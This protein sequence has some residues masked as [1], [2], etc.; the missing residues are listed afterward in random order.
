MWEWWG[1][2]SQMSNRYPRRDVNQEAKA[3]VITEVKTQEY[4]IMANEET[5]LKS[6]V[7]WSCGS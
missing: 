1:V 6:L 5:A 4:L 2:N 3:G 7:V